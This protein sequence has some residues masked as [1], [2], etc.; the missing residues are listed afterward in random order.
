MEKFLPN[1]MGVLKRVLFL[2]PILPLL[3]KASLVVNTKQGWSSFCIGA[4]VTSTEWYPSGR[5]V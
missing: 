2:P 1:I 3:V 5:V 4:A